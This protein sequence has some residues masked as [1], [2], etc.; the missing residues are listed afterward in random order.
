[1]LFY[2]RISKLFHTFA[3]ENNKF[4]IMNTVLLTERGLIELFGFYFNNELEEHKKSLPYLPLTM[5]RSR[6]EY[7]LNITIVPVPDERYDVRIL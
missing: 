5:Y 7:L 2:L 3:L 4:Y 1:M 6:L